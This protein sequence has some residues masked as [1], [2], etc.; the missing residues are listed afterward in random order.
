MTGAGRRTNPFET[1]LT[2]EA[3]AAS[4][5]NAELELCHT[6]CLGCGCYGHMRQRLH[7]IESFSDR[8]PSCEGVEQKEK[9]PMD[10]TQAFTGDPLILSRRKFLL[11]FQ[12]ANALFLNGL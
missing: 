10:G 11:W 12:V 1:A 2:A 7:Y 8:M 9:N 5:P 3:M 6:D 4:L